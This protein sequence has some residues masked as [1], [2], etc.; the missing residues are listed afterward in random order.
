MSCPTIVT[1]QPNEC[2]GNSLNTINSNYQALKT[3]IC[4]N[5]DQINEIRSL[6]NSL[7]TYTMSLTSTIAQSSYAAKAWINF[8][9]L[10]GVANS[11]YNANVTR[12]GTGQYKITFPSGVF[13]NAN[14]AFVGS[15]SD[16]NNS[17]TSGGTMETWTVYWNQNLTKTTTELDIRVSWNSPQGG[18]YGDARQVNLVFFNT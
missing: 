14:Y 6:F 12:T 2:I 5:Q 15:A 8:N 4:D 10:T 11:S 13:S 16:D 9:G 1:I 3:G 7:Q 18:A 17:P